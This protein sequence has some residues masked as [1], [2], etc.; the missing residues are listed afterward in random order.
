MAYQV[1]P[2]SVPEVM[3]YL[4]HREKGGYTLHEV[5]FYPKDGISLS[6]QVLVY[7]ATESN[8]EYLGDAPL[9]EIA[10]QVATSRGPSGENS[11]YLLR[12]AQAVREMGVHD[13]HLFDLEKRVTEELINNRMIE[14]EKTCHL[15]EQDGVQNRKLILVTKQSDD[16]EE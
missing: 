14:A 3:A 1:L 16:G 4:D 10:K 15:N 5:N 9:N 7:I 2:S 12:L 8:E 6:F 11:E 13:D